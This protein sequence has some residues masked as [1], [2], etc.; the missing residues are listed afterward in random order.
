M[1]LLLF[2]I[3]ITTSYNSIARTQTEKAEK[4]CTEIIDVMTIM[5]IQ[6]KNNGKEKDVILPKIIN[7]PEIRDNKQ[8]KSDIM[9]IANFVYNEGYSIPDHRVRG[10]L[11]NEWCLGQI[12]SFTYK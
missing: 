7:L 11:V 9:K 2:I 3:L 5:F 12:D 4:Y 1:K 8:L 10:F 6:A